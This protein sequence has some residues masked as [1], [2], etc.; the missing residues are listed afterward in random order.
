MF[1]TIN[2]IAEGFLAIFFLMA[3]LPK[4]IGRGIERWIGFDQVPRR[5][6][7]LIGMCEVSAATALVVPLL[8]DELSWTTPLAAVGIGV[9][10]LQASGFHLRN[11]EW[12]ASL[13]TALWASLAASVAIARW[14]ELSTGPPD[15]QGRAHPDLAR[16]APRNHHQPHTP[17]PRYRPRQTEGI[18]AG[19]H[20]RQLTAA[21]AGRA[22]NSS[23]WYPKRAGR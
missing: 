3:G 5:L 21:H 17:H 2:W 9:I 11:R 13:E 15:H 6:T 12:L 14:G 19:N 4:I 23:E 8:I 20:R 1:D 7:I 18:P 16:A 10:S 22:I